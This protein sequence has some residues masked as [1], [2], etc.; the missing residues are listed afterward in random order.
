[1]NTYTMYTELASDYADRGTVTS[2]KLR[3]PIP[4]YQALAFIYLP[5]YPWHAE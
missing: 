5:L 4:L 3:K 1:M 2:K